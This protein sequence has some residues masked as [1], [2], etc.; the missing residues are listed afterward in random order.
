MAA[1]LGKAS[2]EFF[3]PMPETVFFDKTFKAI[4]SASAGPVN[5]LISVTIS[6]N[7]TIVYWDHWYVTSVFCVPCD[8]CCE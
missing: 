2:T 8:A 5:T 4:S 6:A 3:I 7:N 1:D